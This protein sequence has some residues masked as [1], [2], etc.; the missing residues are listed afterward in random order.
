MAVSIASAYLYQNVTGRFECK[1]QTFRGSTDIQATKHKKNLHQLH[2]KLLFGKLKGMQLYPNE[3]P[4]L[5][6]QTIH[7]NDEVHYK[8]ITSN[9]TSVISTVL[10]TV[11]VFLT[12]RCKR[13]NKDYH[14]LLCLINVF[15][16]NV[17]SLQIIVLHFAL[18]QGN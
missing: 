8:Q 17:W 7:T 5:L 14:E 12:R 3:K 11:H 2:W 13:G 4:Y 9:N 18:F 10:E 1:L 15:Y 6:I 16:T